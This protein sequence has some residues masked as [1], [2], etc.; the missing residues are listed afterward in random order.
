M[1]VC[2]VAENHPLAAM[3]G[4]EYQIQLICDE[5]LRRPGVE[6]HYLA[7]K[8]PAESSAARLPYPIHCIGSDRGIR[9]R[10]TFFD[11]PRLAA[12]LEELRPDVIYQRMKQSY[13]AVCARHANRRSIP[14]F[15]H[16]ASM[17][18]LDMDLLRGG[19]SPNTPF[20]VVET[21]LGNR[22]LRQAPAVFA[23]TAAQARIL[24]ERTGRDATAV[25]G[26]FQP[27]PDRLPPPAER[28]PWRVLW[29]GNLK[30]VKR[31]ERFLDLADR[32]RGRDDF[33]FEMVGRPWVNRRMAPVM[34]R[35]ESAP[36]LVYHG[37]L[38]LQAV[39]E[40]MTT[41]TFH[42][43]TSAFEGFPNTFI[44]AWSRGAVV[45][46]LEVDPF[47]GIEQVGVGFRA[48]SIERMAE[49]LDSLVADR[50]RWLQLREQ[51]FRYVQVAHSLSQAGRLVDML[52]DSA[53]AARSAIRT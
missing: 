32:F 12:K 39:N 24:R 33:I 52:I 48:G 50:Q 38:P 10:A 21:W 19:W 47:E 4:A 36:N 31:P 1:R 53:V 14:F 17:M 6:L 46:S 45:I 23:Q 18:D 26:N 16:V 30:E 51:S 2:I 34:S 42:V 11:A 27:L 8:V 9:R 5:L 43:N 29:V 3:G 7:R 41:A 37:E 20:D 28:P 49:L 22:G 40:L 13:T 15:F 35:I 25:I 44:Q